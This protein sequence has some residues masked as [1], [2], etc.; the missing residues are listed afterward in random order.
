MFVGHNWG[1][2]HDPDTA[3]CAPT[4]EY[5]GH[6]LMYPYAVTG[7]DINNKVLLIFCLLSY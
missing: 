6:Y 2:E 3:D 1:S 4:S 7:Y 5:G